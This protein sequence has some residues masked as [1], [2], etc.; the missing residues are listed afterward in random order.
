MGP[1]REIVLLEH[2]VNVLFGLQER[3]HH[4][5][6]AVTERRYPGQGTHN[7]ILCLVVYEE[8][9][10]KVHNDDAELVHHQGRHLVLAQYTYHETER[11]A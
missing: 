4:G 11:G 9:R 5:L 10:A 6:A 8:P 7:H 2:N 1:Q 3:A